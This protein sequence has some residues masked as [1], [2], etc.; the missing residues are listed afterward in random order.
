MS[1]ITVGV[2]RRRW[3]AA[4]ATSVVAA[5]LVIGGCSSDAGSSA[6]QATRTVTDLAGRQVVVPTHI[7]RIATVGLV[8]PNNSA[9][10]AL[11]ESG[12]VVNGPPSNWS[13]TWT[14][15]PILAPTVARAPSLEST[16]NGPIQQEE[17]LKLHPDVVVASAAAMADQ[18]EK[19]GIPAVVVTISGP[20]KVKQSMTLLGEIF[21]KQDL[22]K[23]YVAYYDRSVAKL[24]EVGSKAH[25]NGDPTLLYMSASDPMRRPSVS[26]DWAAKQLGATPVTGTITAGGWYKFNTEQLLAWDPETIITMFPSDEHTLRTDPRFALLQAVKSGNIHTTPVGA[27][28]WG[29]GTAEDPLGYLWLA[30]TLYPAAAAD[31]DLAAETKHFYSTFFGVDLTDGQVG[32]ILAVQPPAGA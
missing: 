8:P 17:L 24:H 21:G 1:P 19:L 3:S 18:V 16:I 25:A 29:Q 23:E 6:A 11:G 20:D 26:M 7:E 32:R 2:G 14:N 4:L 31:I 27:Q 10:F 15:Y 22:A 30:K 9:V 12:H 13:E 5:A 28:L